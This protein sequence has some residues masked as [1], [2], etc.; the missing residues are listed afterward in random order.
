VTLALT[1]GD[2]SGI[3]PEVTAKALR[4]LWDQDDT[5]YVVFGDRRY[6]MDA[7]AAHA[8]G[9][10]ALADQPWIPEATNGPRLTWTDAG[11]TLPAFLS[12]GEISAGDAA[13][14]WVRAATL[15]CLDK[16]L[17]GLITAPLN[18]E[19]V[20]RSG[21]AGFTGQTEFIAHL[22]GSDRFAMMLLGHDHRDRWLRVALVTTHLPL[23]AVPAAIQPPAIRRAIALASEA[24]RLLGLPRQ[25]V[26]VC[27]LNPHAGEGGMLG[28]E[29]RDIIGPTVGKAR[30][31]GI[32]VVGPLA[33][34]TLF[35]RALEGDFDAVVAQYHD[36]GLAPLKLVAFDNG[37]NW[38]LGLP[39]IRTS[40]DHGTAYDIAGLGVANSSSMECAIRLAMAVIRRARAAGKE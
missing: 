25:R 11:V 39:F 21:H 23:R 18:K 33:A 31:D 27:G 30:N 12:P 38:T 2:V 9:L 20:I 35:H 34:D 40:P 24:C 37:V 3:G 15:A 7:L 19:S 36:Q 6:W 26:G 22:A 29:D 10:R 8:P 13:L 16:G 14:Q 1:L 4:C 28:N 32:D 5:R 17:D